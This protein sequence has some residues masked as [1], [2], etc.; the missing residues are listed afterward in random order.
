[1]TREAAAAAAKEKAAAAALPLKLPNG[2][3]NASMH[4][5]PSCSSHSDAVQPTVP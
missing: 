3:P 4:D 2:E 5:F 1:M